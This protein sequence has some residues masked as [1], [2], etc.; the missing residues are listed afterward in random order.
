MSTQVNKQITKSFTAELIG[1][2][3]ALQI[4]NQYQT[5]QNISTDC[6]SATKLL[7]PK[8][9]ADWAHHP[10]NQLLSAIHR[11]KRKELKWTPSH[12]ER[13]KKHRPLHKREMWNH[14]SRRCM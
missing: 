11:L 4:S 13:K 9:P 5:A 12:P 7:N 8:K 2:L 1:I 6:Q 14:I 10:Q 3:G